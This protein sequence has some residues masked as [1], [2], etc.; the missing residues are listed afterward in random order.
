M[1]WNLMIIQDLT[2]LYDVILISV[3]LISN[4]FILSST[5]K[6]VEKIFSENY[7]RRDLYFFLKRSNSIRV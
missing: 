2:I 6:N 7:K 1:P 4:I 5:T 3:T